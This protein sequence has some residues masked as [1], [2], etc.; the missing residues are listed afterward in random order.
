M[1]DNGEVTETPKKDLGGRPP[2]EPTEANRQKVITCAAVGIPQMD[3]ARLLGMSINTLRKHYLD[4]LETGSIEANVAIGGTLFNKAKS[5]DTTAMIW[6]TKARM[7]WTD[8]QGDD[9]A[10]SMV[11]TIKELAKRLPD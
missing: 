10:D 11:E 4:E 7:G 9:S 5:G 2:H 1:T 8:K 3:V 6:W